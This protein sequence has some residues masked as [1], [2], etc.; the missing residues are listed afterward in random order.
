MS[1]LYAHPCAR[2]DHAGTMMQMDVAHLNVVS[3]PDDKPLELTTVEHAAFS[4]D[5]LWLATV[6]ASCFDD[7]Y[8]FVICCRDA[9]ISGGGEGRQE[10]GFR[11][12]DEAMGI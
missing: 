2:P 6:R 8:L 9:C 5:G 3:R 7:L 11:V 12:E 10:D 1:S 4:P